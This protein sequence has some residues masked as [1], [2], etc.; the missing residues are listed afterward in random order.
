MDDRN[1]LIIKS[2]NNAG[3][4]IGSSN[5]MQSMEQGFQAVHRRISELREPMTERMSQCSNFKFL[6]ITNYFDFAFRE[7]SWDLS[8][9]MER[10]AF[11][12]NERRENEAFSDILSYFTTS[13]PIYQFKDSRNVDVAVSYRNVNNITVT[14]RGKLDI[15]VV[16]PNELATMPETIFCQCIAVIEVKTPRSLL[17]NR[18]KCINQTRLQVIALSSGGNSHKPFGLLTNMTDYWHFMWIT[19]TNQI[20][21]TI[22]NSSQQGIYALEKGLRMMN[23][24]QSS[25][26]FKNR[27]SV[28]LPERR[29]DGGYTDDV[30]NMEDFYD[31][32]TEQEVFKHKSKIG[33]TRIF[34]TMNPSLRA[35]FT[36]E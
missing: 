7:F 3:Q 14:A 16:L 32:M 8:I 1:P 9:S 36:I 25:C 29:G 10:N 30:A 6:E 24:E 21:S 27:A 5:L 35:Y 31:Q 15:A 12:W 18:S 26:P 33:L 2:T 11:D 4:V 13:M 28:S 23:G 34:E 19:E 20:N 17:D 22:F